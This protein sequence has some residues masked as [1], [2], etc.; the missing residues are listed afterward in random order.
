MVLIRESGA[1]VRNQPDAVGQARSSTASGWLEYARLAARLAALLTAL[2]RTGSTPPP[3]PVL[4][5]S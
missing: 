2:N 3:I 5:L 4:A 1:Y